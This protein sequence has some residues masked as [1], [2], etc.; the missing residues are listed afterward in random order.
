[1]YIEPKCHETLGLYY[2]IIVHEQKIFCTFVNVSVFCVGRQIH[3]KQCVY[4]LFLM[5]ANFGRHFVLFLSLHGD[6]VLRC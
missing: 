3:C 6:D 1:M 2:L 4:V 5:Y